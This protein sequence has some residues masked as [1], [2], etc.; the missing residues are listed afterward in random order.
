MNK[1]GDCNKVVWCFE[2]SE[3]L[4]C[5]Y[6]RNP[7]FGWLSCFA[8]FYKHLQGTISTHNW[9]YL[10]FSLDHYP[11]I[12]FYFYIINAIH[13]DWTLGRFRFCHHPSTFSCLKVDKYW[14][15]VLLSQSEIFNAFEGIETTGGKNA[16]KSCNMQKFQIW[17]VSWQRQFSMN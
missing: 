5:S 17:L 1:I 15:H 2:L 9:S 10:R 6:N 8:I 7:N 4:L 3:T 16:K 13:F 11:G 12:G 14:K